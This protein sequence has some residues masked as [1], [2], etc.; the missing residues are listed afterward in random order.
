MAKLVFH[1]HVSCCG[2]RDRKSQAELAGFSRFR[3]ECKTQTQNWGKDRE[4]ESGEEAGQKPGRWEATCAHMSNGRVHR[5]TQARQ[6]G[7]RRPIGGAQKLE[8][9]DQT[10]GEPLRKSKWGSPP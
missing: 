3:G 10:T 9:Q 7:T 6:T 5:A 2:H 1:W 8:V 4:H